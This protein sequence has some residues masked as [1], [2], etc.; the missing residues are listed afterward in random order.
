[1]RLERSKTEVLEPFAVF[2]IVAGLGI[3]IIIP[4]VAA[5]WHVTSEAQS[6]SAKG[7]WIFAAACGLAHSLVAL[8]S[9]L[10]SGF[11]DRILYFLLAAVFISLI[12]FAIFF[13][14][15]G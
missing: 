2:V 11:L 4:V 5:V 13:P 6:A 7:I 8:R 15:N 9:R 1:M 14:R 3:N 12:A 10:R